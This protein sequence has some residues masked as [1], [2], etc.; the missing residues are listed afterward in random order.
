[1]CPGEECGHWVD[2][3]AVPGVIGA[4]Q[5]QAWHVM[6]LQ[7]PKPFLGPSLQLCTAAQPC[8]LGFPC[9]PPCRQ[10]WSSG[11][12]LQGSMG[13]PFEELHWG[14]W[15]SREMLLGGQL[16]WMISELSSDLG[17]SAIRSH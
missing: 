15:V 2:G 1:M 6:H 10:L 5:Q 12:L 14:M 16:G 7:H 11:V 13:S 17:D 9:F 3:F 8:C 4:F